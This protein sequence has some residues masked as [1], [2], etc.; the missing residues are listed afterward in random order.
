MAQNGESNEE[1]TV[2]DLTNEH[3]H[4]LDN[5]EIKPQLRVLDLTANRLSSIDPRILALTGNM[6]KRMHVGPA[7]LCLKGGA[8]ALRFCIW[9]AHCADALNSPPFLCPQ[10]AHQHLQDS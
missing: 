7:C 2:L 1:A 4:S 6:R 5:V 10:C 8:W 3:L 9:S